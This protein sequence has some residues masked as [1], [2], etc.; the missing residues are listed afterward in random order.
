M[1]VAVLTAN[2][3]GFEQNATPHV[4]QSVSCDFI[5]FDDTNYPRRDKAMSPRLQARIPKMFGWQMAPGYDI[6]IWVDS[7][8]HLQNP[9]SVEWFLSQLQPPEM[10]IHAAFFKHPNRNTIREEADYLKERLAMGCDYITPRYEN[11]EIDMQ[12]QEIIQDE[13][14]IDYKLFASTAF[15]YRDHRKTRELL[16]EWWYHTSRYHIIDQLGLPYAIAKSR[17]NV[18]II[19]DNYTKSPYIKYTR[20][21]P[22]Q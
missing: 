15:V 12:M 19:P 18:R 10:D 22:K 17:C 6:Y 1:R 4:P 16:K 13:G 3:G 11:E 2:M 14:F 7:S 21:L 9:K 8:C 5:A 20:N